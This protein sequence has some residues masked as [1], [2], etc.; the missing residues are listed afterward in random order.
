MTVE[1]QFLGAG[2][3]F[4]RSE[5][6]YHNNCLLYVDGEVYLIDCSLFA[7]ESLHDLGVDPLE[8]D[9]IIL[10]HI[11]GDH[12]SGIEEFGF[13]HHFLGSEGRPYLYAHPNLLPSCSSADEDEHLGLWENCLK[14]G[15]KHL[16]Q[17][18]GSPLE[19]DLETYFDPHPVVPFS[20]GDDVPF[21]FYPVDHAP[22]KDTYGLIFE[23]D[24]NRIFY[25]ADARP[26]TSDEEDS[27][28]KTEGGDED[29]Y[30]RFDIIF[31]DCMFMDFYPATVHTH[32]EELLSLP[33]G[34]Q[35]KIRVMHYGDASEWSDL[36]T[37]ELNIA[38][39]HENY[40]L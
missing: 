12:V 29:F 36:E 24:N 40:H 1:L 11:H 7:L 4:D 32:L 14:G 3:A 38:L 16:C 20:L 39:K 33:S 23:T 35:E 6:N 9:G 19:A 27:F 28:S 37:G 15:M 18:D 2:G 31:H 26:I 25:S 5:T 13:R 22:G 34:I 30:R 21:Q 17:P 8:L 10:T